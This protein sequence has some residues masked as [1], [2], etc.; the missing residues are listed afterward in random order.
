M[1]NTVADYVGCD[2]LE[3]VPLRVSAG[4]NRLKGRGSKILA[5]MAA[6]KHNSSNAL[7]MVVV[8]AVSVQFF[9]VGIEFP[10]GAFKPDAAPTGGGGGGCSVARACVRSS[11]LALVIFADR[12][13]RDWS[14][15]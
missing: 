3:A 4:I 8:V 11:N 1:L 14:R 6:M 10:R 12:T 13:G 9:L 5:S 15:G 2:L 7:I